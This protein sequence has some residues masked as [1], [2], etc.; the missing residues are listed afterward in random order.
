VSFV[1]SKRATASYLAPD[2]TDRDVKGTIAPEPLFVR[3]ASYSPDGGF[4][5]GPL[6]WWI[7]KVEP[8]AD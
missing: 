7:S 1:V 3:D 2:E 6:G 8:P 4:A 5:I